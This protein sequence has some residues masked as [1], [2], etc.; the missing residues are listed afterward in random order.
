M[1]FTQLQDSPPF[2][3]T[4]RASGQAVKREPRSFPGHQPELDPPH[5]KTVPNSCY[6]L[7]FSWQR[8]N[9][10]SAVPTAKLQVTSE[11]QLDK[12]RSVS[13]LE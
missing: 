10:G 8:P 3:Y 7:D 4:L 2:H 12:K 11:E 5:S 1:D 13:G 6:R 9:S